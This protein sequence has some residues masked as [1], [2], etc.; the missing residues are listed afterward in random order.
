MSANYQYLDAER[1]QLLDLEPIAAA[2][3]PAQEAT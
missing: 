1:S 2:V 3:A